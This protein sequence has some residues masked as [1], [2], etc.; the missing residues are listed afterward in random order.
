VREVDFREL[1]SY[2]LTQRALHTCRFPM[3]PVPLARGNPELHLLTLWLFL[4]CSSFGCAENEQTRPEQASGSVIERIRRADWV[5]QIFTADT[6]RLVIPAEFA[7]QACHSLHVSANREIFLVDPFSPAVLRFDRRGRFLGQVGN[8]GKGPGEYV[9]PSQVITINHRIFVSDVGLRRV[10]VY[11]STG[12]FLNSFYAE[13]LLA[14][15]YAGPN[16]TLVTHQLR[17]PHP[18]WPTIHVYSLE[19]KLLAQFGRA[20]ES[21]R[22]FQRLGRN[23]SGPCLAQMDGVYYQ[24]DYTDYRITAYSQDGQTEKVFGIPPKQYRSVQTAPVEKIPRASV[25][26]PAY[27]RQLNRFIEDHFMRC[28]VVEGILAFPRGL[29]A[30]LVTNPRKTGFEHRAY[31]N[32]YTPS[33]E[34]IRNEL[35]FKRR[36]VWRLSPPDKV[37]ALRFAE[38]SDPASQIIDLVVLT[39]SKAE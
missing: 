19:G 3:N 25:V 33:G 27:L 29:L 4:F 28:S 2:F 1:N 10:S 35:P 8:Q 32:F 36:R 24:V 13:S 20:S 7:L 17:V 26:G 15:I 21:Y 14:G 11:D 30:T 34:L 5:E 16:Q 31:L 18:D 22:L 39:L 38:Q 9:M 6:L 23:I 12:L 37:F